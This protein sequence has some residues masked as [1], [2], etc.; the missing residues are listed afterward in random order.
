MNGHAPFVNQ[1]PYDPQQEPNA[2]GSSPAIQYGHTQSPAQPTTWSYNNNSPGERD[3]AYPQGIQQTYN[4]QADPESA[5]NWPPNATGPEGY[6]EWNP[7]ANYQ[8]VDN[9]NYANIDQSVDHSLR[10]P[11]TNAATPDGRTG[12]APWSQPTAYNL[13]PG[14]EGEQSPG[15][16]QSTFQ[17]QSTYTAFP[18]G[19][20]NS[21]APFPA[22]VTVSALPRHAYTRTL[23]GPLSANACRL[24]DEHQ[25][26]GIF[27]LF[28]D[29]SV[30]TEGLSL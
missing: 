2:D 25:K 22:T 30:R 5:G 20:M 13:T 11:P 12:K 7:E 26:P 1:A 4:Q 16:G 18:Q 10:T 27:F 6:R 3:V 14:V 17:T 9:N 19:T 29:L 21:P 8:Q 15:S 28:Q 23:V 24:M